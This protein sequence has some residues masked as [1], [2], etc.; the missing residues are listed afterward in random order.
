VSGLPSR[1]NATETG[2]V[3]VFVFVPVVNGKPDTPLVGL[4]RPIDALEIPA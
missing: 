4:E 1:L 2:F 3:F